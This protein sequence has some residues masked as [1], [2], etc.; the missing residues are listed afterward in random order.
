M[1][2]VLGTFPFQGR[3]TLFHHQVEGLRAFHYLH[4]TIHGIWSTALEDNTNVAFGGQ[5]FV[6]NLP[7]GISIDNATIEV[8]EH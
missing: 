4:A 6:L 8:N 7:D 5:V 2:L 3:G 1:T